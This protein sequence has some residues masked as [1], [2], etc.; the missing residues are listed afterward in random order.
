MASILIGANSIHL[1]LSSED[2]SCAHVIVI[3]SVFNTIL[4]QDR[5]SD[6]FNSNALQNLNT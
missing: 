5:R 2:E 3:I 1:L 4:A 6:I